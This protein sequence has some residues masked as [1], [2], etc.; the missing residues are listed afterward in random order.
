M[1]HTDHIWF[2]TPNIVNGTILSHMWKLLTV[3]IPLSTWI[4]REAID[5]VSTTEALK[6]LKD[7]KSVV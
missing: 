2:T 5:C 7:R 6:S 4:R 3:F 1:A